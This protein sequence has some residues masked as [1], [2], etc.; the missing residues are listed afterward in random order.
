MHFIMLNKLYNDGHLFFLFD[1]FLDVRAEIREKK[2][3]E[4]KKPQFPFEIS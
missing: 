1:H 3:W 4:L 2:L